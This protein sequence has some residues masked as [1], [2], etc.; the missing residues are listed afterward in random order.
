LSAPWPEGGLERVPACPLCGSRERTP[1]HLGIADGAYENTPGRWDL[2]RCAGCGC[3]FL[4]PRPTR[5]SIPLAYREYYTHAAPDGGGAGA[6]TG[7]RRVR[8]ALANGYRNWR[9]G[10]RERPATR[11]GV[12]AAWLFPA[13]RRR[14]DLEFR[15]LPR[16]WPGARLLDVGFGD[17][18]FLDRA[19]SA[20]WQVTGVDPDPVTVDAARRRG[21][22]VREGILD[23]LYD[24]LGPFD[25]VTLSHVIEHV[26]DP[27]AFVRRIRA[28]L[29][30]GGIVWIETPNLE[31][32]GHRRF[33]AAWR[34][35]E[36]PRHLV[37]FGWDS[38]EALL[39]EA[40]FAALRRLPRHEVYAE[41]A[42]KSLAIRR[43]WSP[44]RRPAPG[45]G[46]RIANR[47]LGLGSRFDYR[48]S[49][50]VT[51]IAASSL[52]APAR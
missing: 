33:G 5:E 16:P 15:H 24:G 20:G 32:S 19:R 39:R 2:Y 37:L 10:T 47:L 7:M 43:G 45:P 23:V 49:E 12:P 38:L 42:P 44:R 17:G 22:D 14:I 29:K 35:L 25:V 41:Q 52:A 31:G 8:R 46:E 28:L 26:H 36:P 6:L 48:R 34:G 3:A 4:D 30:P 27:R 40:G 18:A 11:M 1:L 51:L 21:L 13:T 9:Y 50:Y